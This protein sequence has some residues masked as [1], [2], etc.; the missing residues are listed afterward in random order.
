M[1]AG[2]SISKLIIRFENESI[3]Q[4]RRKHSLQ[5]SKQYSNGT[6]IEK[7]NFAFSISKSKKTVINTAQ[8]IQF[9]VRL[10]F[11]STAHKVQ[12]LTIKKP[13]KLIVNVMDTFAAAMIYVMLSRV[14]SLLQI[15]I[16][17]EFNESKMY[18][19]PKAM[20]KLLR[21]EELSLNNNPTEWEKDKNTLKI[22]S[23][24][25]RSLKKHYQDI[26]TD[27]TV[28]ESSIICLQET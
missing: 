1:G 24:N 6:T 10:A 20:E 14:C 12:G 15:Y 11:A 19:N 3:G 26:K 22:Y 23:L 25:C 2:G 16:M 17:N 13:Q 28:I 5:I 8:V 21:L 7:V 4:E 18:P 27:S 9:P